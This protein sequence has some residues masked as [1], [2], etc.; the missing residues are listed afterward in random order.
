MGRKL[1]FRLRRIYLRPSFGGVRELLTMLSTD[2][3]PP[4]TVEQ[5]GSNGQATRNPRR[6]HSHFLGSKIEFDLPPSRVP[7]PP[8]STDPWFR[9]EPWFALAPPSPQ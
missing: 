5:L 6:T 8:D 9:G 1:G 3:Q 4:A 7:D 2:L